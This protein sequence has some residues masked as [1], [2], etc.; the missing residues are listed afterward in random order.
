MKK[1]K[2]KKE[3][4]LWPVWRWAMVID[5]KKCTGCG[6]CVMACKAENNVPIVTKNQALQS[7]DMFWIR[8]MPVYEGKF[9]EVK[10]RYIPVPCMHCEEPPCIRVC[11][12]GATYFSEETGIVGQIFGRCIGCRY[13]TVACPYTVRV[14]NWKTPEFPGDTKKSI[15]PDVSVRPR[16]VVEK[17]TFCSHRLQSA[18][19]RARK[20]GGKIKEGDY[21][22]ACVES[23]PAGAMYFGDLNDP[24]STVSKLARDPRAFRL[25]EDLGTEPKVIYLREGV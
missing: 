9:P 21:L 16:G 8:L 12:V 2:A 4:S 3:N 1:G 11:P 10:M 20:N 25:I 18:K 7:R 15:N 5:L 24:E 17:C 19:D 13:C 14:F 6:A 23:C 22:P